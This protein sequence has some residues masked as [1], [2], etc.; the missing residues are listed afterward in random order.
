MKLKTISLALI[1][2]T[3]AIAGCGGSS[4]S[5]GASSAAATNAPST[6]S[7]ATSTT[8]PATTTTPSS[9]T[10]TFASTSNCQQLAD[11]GAKYLSEVTAA[12]GGPGNIGTAL[13]ADQAMADAAPS[14]IHSQ[15]EYV[16]H[17]FSGFVN[18][19][20]KSGY[21]I[22]TTPTASQ[23]AALAS[24]QQQFKQSTFVADIDHIDAWIHHNCNGVT[25]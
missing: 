24:A 20:T 6:G 1:T 12:G 13:K 16:V 22:G 21:K 3:L 2:A 8:A 14:A 18:T 7:G 19:I 17:V 9:S 15:A 23:L 5:S 4:S 11:L 10:P 25:P